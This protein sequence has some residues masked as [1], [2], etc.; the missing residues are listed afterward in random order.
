[1]NT[2]RRDWKALGTAGVTLSFVLHEKRSYKGSPLYDWL[3]Q[4]AR[5]LGIAGGSVYHGIAGY[6]RHGVL[7]EQ[8]FFELAGDLPVQVLFVCSE[9]E[10]YRL[11]DEIA[12]RGLSLFYSMSPTLH[13][14]TG[15]SGPA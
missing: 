7:H 9:S 3:L 6:G 15:T 11:L 2:D 4:R 12:E 13:G 1:M 5:E 14:I 10:A 8:N